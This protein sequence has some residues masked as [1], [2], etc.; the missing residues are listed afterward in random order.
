M[1]VASSAMWWGYRNGRDVT[2]V[3]APLLA[4]EPLAALEIGLSPE[5]RAF[6]MVG[7]G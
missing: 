1:L 4:R 2:D 5:V 3:L 6:A 7:D